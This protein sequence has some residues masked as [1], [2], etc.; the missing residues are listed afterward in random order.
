MTNYKAWKMPG[1]GEKPIWVIVDETGKTINKSPTEDELKGLKTFP[2]EKYKYRRCGNQKYT[3]EELLNEL[4]RFEKE[5]G[6]IPITKDFTNNPEYPG[7]KI[8]YTRFG[9]WIDVLKLAGLDVDLMGY[10]SNRHKGRVA[11]IKVINHFKQ[12]PI[13]LAGENQN[14]HCDGICP[15]GKTYDV[16]SSKLREYK[17]WSFSTRNKYKE[18]IEIYYFLAFNEDYTKLKYAW[19]V[20]GEIIEQNRFAVGLT[21]D[22]EFNIENMK[23]YDITDKFEDINVINDIGLYESKEIDERCIKQ[24]NR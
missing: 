11:E 13:D 10:Q 2:K 6:R 21:N 23:E 19:R 12:H 20:F 24:R 9:S 15:N 22:Y 18:D 4:R 16:K 17:Y 3:D 7:F 5:E 14:S 8:Y 1:I